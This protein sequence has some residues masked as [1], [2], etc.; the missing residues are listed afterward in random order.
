MKKKLAAS[1]CLRLLLAAFFCY[2]SSHGNSQTISTWPPRSGNSDWHEPSNWTD[3]VPTAPGDVATVLAARRIGNPIVSAPIVLGQLTLGT[4]S[5]ALPISVTG[6]S[7]ITFD[8]P[9]DQPAVLATHPSLTQTN[10]IVSTPIAIAPAESLT[11]DVVSGSVLRLEGGVASTVGDI[12]KVGG[13]ALTLAGSGASWGGSLTVAGGEVTVADAT[14]LGTDAAATLI[15]AA[16]RIV[17]PSRS[18]IAEPFLL[19]GGILATSSSSG[20]VNLNGTI[21]LLSDSVLSV[22]SFTVVN[23]AVTG[24]GGLTVVAGGSRSGILNGDNS[25]LGTTILQG[26]TLRIEHANGLGATSAGTIV[27]GGELVLLQPVLEPLTLDG[28]A[29]LFATAATS[30][31]ALTLKTGQLNLPRDATFTSPIVLANDGVPPVV[32]G[33]RTRLTGGISGVGDLL[34]EGSLTIDQTPLKHDG[35]FIVNGPNSNDIITLNVANTFTGS[36]LVNRG[37]LVVNNEQA[38]GQST[39]VVEVAPSGRLVLNAPLARDLDVAGILEVGPSI[40][41]DNAIV[42]RPNFSTTGVASAILGQGVFRGEIVIGDDDFA[43]TTI[44]GGTFEG[45]LTG[46]ARRLNLGGNHP[47]ALN[48]DNAYQGITQVGSNETVE[49]NA[50]LALGGTQHGTN[51]IAGTLNVNVPVEERL[52][53]SN[54]GRINLNVQQSRLPRIVESRTFNPAR[55]HVVAINHDGSYLEDVDVAE[56]ALEINANVAIRR[57]TVRSAGQLSVAPGATLQVLDHEIELQNGRVEGSLAGVQT[58]RKTTGYNAQLGDLPGY[59][60]D[61]RVEKGNLT[62]SSIGGFGT[63]TGATH[64]LGQDA[65]LWIAAPVNF[66]LQEDIFLHDARGVADLTGISAFQVGGVGGNVRLAGRLDLGEQGSAIGGG[67][68]ELTGSVT[69]GD[70][71]VGK[72]EV[73]IYTPNALHTGV[74]DVRASLRLLAA[75]RVDNTERI[76]L[77]ERPGSDDGRLWIDNAGAGVQ[78]NRI[79]DTTPIEF[80]GGVLQTSGNLNETVGTVRFVEGYSEIDL[81]FISPANAPDNRLTMARLDRN[82]GAVATIRDLTTAEV[83]VNE[84]PSLS[85]GILPWLVAYQQQ[86]PG[87]FPIGFATTSSRGITRMPIDS[88]DIHT[89][90]ADEHVAIAGPTGALSSDATIAS[91]FFETDHGPL[92]LNGFELDVQSG[93]IHLSNGGQVVGGTVSTGPQ[94]NNEL[95]FYGRGSVGAN[96]VQRT[97]A[98]LDVTYSPTVSSYAI[99][100]SGNNQYAGTTFVNDGEVIFRSAES[101]PSNTDLSISGGLAELDFGGSKLLNTIRVSEGGTLGSGFGGQNSLGFEQL[102]LESGQV[103]GAT[104]IGNGDVDKTTD[105]VAVFTG[106]PES[107]FSGRVLVEDGVLAAQAFSEATYVVTGGNLGMFGGGGQIELAGGDLLFGQS[108]FAASDYSLDSPIHVSQASRIVGQGRDSITAELTGELTGD[109]ELTF[110]GRGLDPPRQYHLLTISSDSPDYTGNVAIDTLA[111]RVREEQSLGTGTITVGPAGSLQ[112]SPFQGNFENAK[113]DLANTVSLQG[114]EIR[115]FDSVHRPQQLTGDLFVSGHSFVSSMNVAGA[116]HLADRSVLTTHGDGVL[117]FLGD[118]RVGGRAGLEYGL[119]VI[120][121]NAADLDSGVVQVLG[122]I[123]SDAEHAE[124]DLIGNGLDDILLQASLEAIDGQTLTLLKDGEKFAVPLS[125][126]GVAARGNGVIRNDL[127]LSDGAAISPGS[128]AGTLTVEGNVSLGAGAVYDWE[129]SESGGDQLVV[130]GTLEFLAT[131]EDPWVFRI[132]DLGQALAFEDSEWLVA[133]ASS[134]SGFS[135]AI[136]RFEMPTLSD[137]FARPSADRVSLELRGSELY[138]ILAVP[139]PSCLLFSLQLVVLCCVVRRYL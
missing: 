117:Q 85:H 110:T 66:T 119:N 16:G 78:N 111:V 88:T 36:T 32:R 23:G 68:I 83:H 91:L 93:A 90:A 84:Q 21:E 135:Q 33:D 64:V 11:I 98:P 63:T 37:Q 100:V 99:G 116:L 39:T 89:A 132:T 115:G 121:A 52:V 69:G 109:A 49:I 80:R 47:V 103:G 134:A 71:I 31:G 79:P 128:S 5:S 114:G 118:I 41:L 35:A 27:E 105:G 51:V 137:G 87:E 60:G 38:L 123:V 29:I 10:A 28:G 20:S 59:D 4:A 94:G 86:T 6:T 3:G 56:G 107:S 22:D 74:T 50:P 55:S 17:L 125:S 120:G 54:R 122:A 106:S 43:D 62:I 97:A 75:G 2:V 53:A 126:P 48:S 129:L 81:A 108:L 40:D 136:A 96:I 130:G 15:G 42:M 44:G 65:S 113:L 18:D 25:Y 95:F 127:M 76:I 8:Q 1:L 82:P 73:T 19:D 46:V 24:S 13:G 104:I 61:I 92:D 131:A 14:A 58:I 57:A 30:T 112:L 102:H 67:N 9:G 101:L 138:L 26:G 133:T 139:E 34:V 7:V 124:L 12:S 70:L 77:H 72:G 45:V